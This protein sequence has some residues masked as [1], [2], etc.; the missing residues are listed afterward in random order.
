MGVL[1]PFL[2]YNIFGK[3][4]KNRKIFMGDSGSLTL[5]YILGVLLVKF[6]MV[7][8]N[9]MAY[10]KGSILFSITLLII[11]IFDVCRVIIVRIMHGHG[12]F[13]PDKNHIHHKFMRAGLTQHQALIAILALAI[14]FI[15]LN[16]MLFCW[17][18]PT[19]I[20]LID[21]ALFVLLNVS[22]LNPIIKRNN[23]QPFQE[24]K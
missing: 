20:I 17:V 18:S 19:I 15:I 13:H 22:V 16:T 21:I 4:E 24:D 14:A 6:C 1:V 9:V 3:L 8:P 11:P 2:Y 12:I 23:K 10:R 5:G 7:N